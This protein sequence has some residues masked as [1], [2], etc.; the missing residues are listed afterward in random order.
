MEQQVNSVAKDSPAKEPSYE[1][2]QVYHMVHVIF[3]WLNDNQRTH[4][5]I[6]FLP[7]QMEIEDDKTVVDI[8][9][10]VLETQQPLFESLPKNW[11]CVQRGEPVVFPNCIDSVDSRCAG[12]VDSS[13]CDIVKQMETNEVHLS[14]DMALVYLFMKAMVLHPQLQN[15][16][17]KKYTFVFVNN[18][19]LSNTVL[20]R[21]FRTCKSFPTFPFD[22]ER[23]FKEM[24]TYPLGTVVTIFGSHFY[25]LL[26]KNRDLVR[27]EGA[28]FVRFG[29]D[30]EYMQTTGILVK[31]PDV[32][33]VFVPGLRTMMPGHFK[34]I[35][36]KNFLKFMF[37]FGKDQLKKADTRLLKQLQSVVPEGF[38]LEQTLGVVNAVQYVYLK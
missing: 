5:E 23:Q 13:V 14:R 7:E 16:N 26:Q 35:S 4:N 1:H 19:M 37:K 21:C 6:D 34:L 33:L 24:E 38:N 10:H 20:P 8:W 17:N 22:I 29:T 28:S 2:L 9:K 12:Y 36:A 25:W 30:G 3:K 32:L 15:D 11:I 27:P 31:H 18:S